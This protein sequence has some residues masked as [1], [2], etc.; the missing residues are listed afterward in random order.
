MNGKKAKMLRKGFEG[1]LE[2][3]VKKDYTSLNKFEKEWLSSF[4][5]AKAKSEEK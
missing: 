4:Y 2:K 1:K 5:K 3:R